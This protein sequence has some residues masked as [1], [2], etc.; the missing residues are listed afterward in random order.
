M[1]VSWVNKSSL[2]GSAWITR[3]HCGQATYHGR[4]AFT[5]SPCL[6]VAE[7]R[8]VIWALE[9]LRNMHITKVEIASDCVAAM[10][11]IMNPF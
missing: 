2:S 1:N 6:T 8:C 4:D 11:A 9:A 7:L 5:R 3:D 10:E